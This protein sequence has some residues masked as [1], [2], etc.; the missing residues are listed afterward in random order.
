MEVSYERTPS[1]IRIHIRDQGEGFDWQRYANVDA[2]RVFDAHG[3]GIAV[4]RI[5]SF[6]RVEYLG[7]GNE[8][9]GVIRL[10]G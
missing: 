10:E 5:M 9:V 6:D 3:R 2:S 7:R 8:V 1:E 4:A